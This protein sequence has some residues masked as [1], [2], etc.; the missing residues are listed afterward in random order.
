MFAEIDR[1]TLNLDSVAVERAI[2]PRT[3]AILVVHTFGVPAQMDALL[4]IA[5]WAVEAN[6]G[7]IE[8]QSEP[9]SGSAFTVW[10]PLSWAAFDGAVIVPGTEPDRADL[11]GSNR[12]GSESGGDS[13]GEQAHDADLVPCG[14]TSD[15]GS[16][17]RRG[18]AA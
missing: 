5:R 8:V 17:R 11:D 12:S 18:A 9:G 6:G 1:V 7:S 16:P 13:A 4:A 3:R 14:A 2:T 15:D 10:L